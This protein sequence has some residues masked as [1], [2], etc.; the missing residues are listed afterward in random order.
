MDGTFMDTD[1]DVVLTLVG[2]GFAITTVCCPGCCTIWGCVISGRTFR[3]DGLYGG[4]LSILL[5]SKLKDDR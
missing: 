5:Y 1:V 4:A 3:Y 2:A